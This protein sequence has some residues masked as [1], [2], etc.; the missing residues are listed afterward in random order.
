MM[1]AGTDRPLV[2]ARAEHGSQVK[3][4]PGGVTLSP[5]K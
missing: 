1:P 3:E 5:S 4:A 2:L